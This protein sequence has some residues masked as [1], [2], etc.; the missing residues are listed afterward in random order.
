VKILVIDDDVVARTQLAAAVQ[1]AG[2]VAIRASDGQRG[3]QVLDDNPDVALVLTDIGM[4]ILSGDA[5]LRMI[6][7]SRD[8][9]RLPVVVVTVSSAPA[10]QARFQQMGANWVL[11]KPIDTQRVIEAIEAA[12]KRAPIKLADD[13]RLGPVFDR[14]ELL[15]RM[16]GDE[17]LARDVIAAYLGEQAR[18]WAELERAQTDADAVLTLKVL[19]R[20]KG[21]LVNL[22]APRA[23]NVAIEVEAAFRG[24]QGDAAL[25]RTLANALSELQ[26]VLKA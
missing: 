6:R 18:V 9:Q 1:R 5:L 22:G 2:H 15:A 8:L 20:M 16:G 4:P 25:V 19:H 23:A 7:A 14:R 21:M 10:E 24:G 17:G 26:K 12:L 11:A 13:A 3:W